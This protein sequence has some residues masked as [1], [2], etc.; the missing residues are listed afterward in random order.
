MLSR[1]PEPFMSVEVLEFDLIK[2]VSYFNAEFERSFQAL[3][4]GETLFENR[5]IHIPMKSH[6]IN[7]STDLNA[8]FQSDIIKYVQQKVDEVMVEGS[9]FTLSKILQLRVQIFKYEPLRG[10]GDIELPKQLKNKKAI[11]NWAHELN[12]NGIDFPVRLNQIEKFMQQNEDINSKC[13]L[14]GV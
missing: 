2:T 13:I 7:S 3:D 11:I 1:P 14:Y 5:E 6:E 10:S 9:G 8:H 4:H 12:F